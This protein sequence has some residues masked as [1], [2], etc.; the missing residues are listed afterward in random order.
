MPGTHCLRT[1]ALAVTSGWCVLLPDICMANSFFKSLLKITFA[2]GS[3]PDNFISLFSAFFL[4]T[5]RELQEI[6]SLSALFQLGLLSSALRVTKAAGNR[7]ANFSL[8]FKASTESN[9]HHLGSYFTAPNKFMWLHL[10]SKGRGKCIASLPKR[11]AVNSSNDYHACLIVSSGSPWLMGLSP[12][13]F[14][15][16]KI[17][18]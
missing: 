2:V 1:F 17:S 13:S 10:T 14:T 18:A 8:A 12:N 7:H 5:Q 16:L 6:R 9:M 3:S 4:S 11:R 15:E